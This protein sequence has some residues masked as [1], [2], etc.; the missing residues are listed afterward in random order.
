MTAAIQPLCLTF[1]EYLNYN[2]G[3]DTRYELVKGELIPMSL[4]T[5]KHGNVAKFLEQTYD[6]EINCL[7]LD[8]TA[9]RAVGI[10]SPRGYRW[11]TCRIPDVT[12]LTT[13]QWEEMGNREAVIRAHEPPP[14]L[15]VEVV[16]PSTK[17]EDYR[18]KWVEYAALDI[19]EYWIVDLIEE[20]VTICILEDGCYQN[21][22]F[23]GEEVITSPTFPQ[24]LLTATQILNAKL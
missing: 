3:T 8:W 4:G 22:L 14:K 16:S 5:G 20:T 6:S 1:D 17:T 9:Q 19:A 11:D 21:T 23:I 24:L 12:V 13:Q 2:D 7:A 15:V 10:Q 18:S